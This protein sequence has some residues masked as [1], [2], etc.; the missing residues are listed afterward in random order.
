[1]GLVADARVQVMEL[2]SGG[3]LVDRIIDKVWGSLTRL[4]AAFTC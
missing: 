4:T 1:V 3:E 2:C